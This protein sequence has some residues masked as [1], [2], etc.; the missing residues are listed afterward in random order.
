M[1]TK[2]AEQRCPDCSRPLQ[3]VSDYPENEVWCLH[4]GNRYLATVNPTDS[5]N[6]PAD[7]ISHTGGS[8]WPGRAAE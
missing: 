5:D 6:N 1:S 3:Q 7:S 2:L 4:C 8:T